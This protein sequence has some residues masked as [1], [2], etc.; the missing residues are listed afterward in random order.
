MIKDIAFQ[1]FMSLMFFR[2]I[3]HQIAIL[4]GY[5]HVAFLALMP[6]VCLAILAKVLIE[7]ER[8]DEWRLWR[9]HTNQVST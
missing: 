4:A 6:I 8:Q 1:F 5:I 7:M 3:L 9:L 2:I